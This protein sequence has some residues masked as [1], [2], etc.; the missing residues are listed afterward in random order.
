MS[1]LQSADE[2]DP[3]F[4][5]SHADPRGIRLLGWLTAKKDPVHERPSVVDFQT[6]TPPK[7]LLSVATPGGKQSC[8]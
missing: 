2:D 1:D 7:D 6:F 8:E 5:F 3:R 4:R